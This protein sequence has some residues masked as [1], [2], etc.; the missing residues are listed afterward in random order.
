M[1]EPRPWHGTALPLLRKK[2]SWEEGTLYKN[3]EARFKFLTSA[4]YAV[5]V[6][7]GCFKR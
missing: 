3:F 4:Q 6:A 5:Y 7:V 1:Y 2:V